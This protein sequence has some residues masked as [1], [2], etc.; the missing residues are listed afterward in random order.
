MRT[1]QAFGAMSGPV[2]LL[3]VNNFGVNLGFYLIVPHLATHLGG[4]GLTVG[5]VGLVIAMRSVSQ[6]GM[7]LASGSAADRIGPRPLI[8]L[9]C[10]LRTVGFGMFAFVESLPAVLVASVLTGLAGAVFAPAARTYLTR[11]VAQEKRL[12]AY[13]VYSA[14]HNAG[15]LLGPLLGSALLLVDFAAVAIVAAGIFAVLTVWQAFALPPQPA[16]QA[17]Q[18]VMRDWREVVATPGFAVYTIAAAGLYVAF[19]QLYLLLPLEAERVT[20]F[21]GAISAVFVVNTVIGLVGSVP[22]TRFFVTRFGSAGALSAGLALCAAAFAVLAVS[23]T[24]QPATPAIAEFHPS[25]LPGLLWS[26]TPLLLSTVVLSI[27]CTVAFPVS[28]DLAVAYVRSGLSGTALG[29]AGT[30]AGV[31]GAAGTA[32]AGVLTDVAARV[33]A[34]ALPWAAMTALCGA[35]AGTLVLLRRRGRVPV[36]SGFDDRR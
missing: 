6:Q 16:E 32:L 33:G 7:T 3:V 26:M 24:W 19:N 13:S 31:I 12:V 29:L 8:L 15:A 17:K 5:A 11:A 2:R 20:G 28:S 1:V 34:P 21:A 36:G 9:G 25:A 22:I 14:A 18:S 30:A 10:G 35:S 27:G 4:L 23:A